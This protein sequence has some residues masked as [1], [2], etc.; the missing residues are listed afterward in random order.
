M[1]SLL[2][3]AAYAA[4]GWRSGVR[5]VA[6]RTLAAFPR[7]GKITRL[8]GGD[9]VFAVEGRREG[10]QGRSGFGTVVDEVVHRAPGDDDDIS[11]LHWKN[12]TP[13]MYRAPTAQE[14]DHEI[15]RCVHVR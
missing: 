2:L 9:L 8:F 5:R 15:V 4:A 14:R 1:S 10:H 3:M 6:G 13:T 11:H 12:S 7:A